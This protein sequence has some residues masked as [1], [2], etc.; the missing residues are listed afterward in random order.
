M[1]STTGVN[2]FDRGVKCI[3]ADADDDRHPSMN[4]VYNNRARRCFQHSTGRPKKTEQNLIVR[5]GKSE[6]EVT[7]NK[8]RY[9]KLTTERQEASRSLSATAELL[10]YS[11]NQWLSNCSDS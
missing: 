4:L 3:T 7:N 10:V 11:K 8:R 6:A 9:S 2:S 1:A 5:T